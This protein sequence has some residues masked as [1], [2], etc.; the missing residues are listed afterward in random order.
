M[1]DFLDLS[2]SLSVSWNP[3]GFFHGT[4]MKSTA[5]RLQG[6]PGRRPELPEV[7]RAYPAAR[8]CET[9]ARLRATPEGNELAKLCQKTAKWLNCAVGK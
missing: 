4:P 6:L 1:T 8:C 9:C 7:H 2:C 3:Y 5:G